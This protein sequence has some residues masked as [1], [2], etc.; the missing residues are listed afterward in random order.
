[1]V[2]NREQKFHWE[3]IGKR[4][5]PSHPVIQTYSSRKLNVILQNLRLTFPKSQSDP[6]YTLL[7]VGAGNGFFSLGLAEH[8]DIKCLDFSQRM[9]Q[10][11]PFAADRKIVGDVCRLP[12]HDKAFDIVFCANLLHHIEDPEAALSEMKR[13]SSKRVVVIEPNARNPLMALFGLIVPTER[14][15]LRFTRRF[16]S[17]VADRVGL[18]PRFLTAH[19]A[20]LPNKTPLPLL[21]LLS[22]FDRCIPLGFYLIGIFEPK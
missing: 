3:H 8:F 6:P 16:L 12:F 21:R 1:M 20:L 14:G 4:R 18:A 2:D 5:P 7:E 11:H 9:L 13:V 10:L 17:K 15:T 22:P 19:G